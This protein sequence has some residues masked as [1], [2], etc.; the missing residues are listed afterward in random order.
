MNLRYL[1]K[2]ENFQSDMDFGRFNDEE[3]LKSFVDDNVD[4]DDFYDRIEDEGIINDD[5]EN[6]THEED[7]EDEKGRIWGDEIVEK[8]KRK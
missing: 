1:K 3:E 8:F 7:R 2:F 6:D 4:F 5:E